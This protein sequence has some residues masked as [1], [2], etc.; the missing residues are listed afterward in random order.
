VSDSDGSTPPPTQDFLEAFK[1]GPSWARGAKGGSKA[2][3]AKFKEFDVPE[4]SGGRTERRGGGRGRGERTDRGGG[5]GFRGERRSGG[6]Q[7]R[8]GGGFRGDRRDSRDGRRDNRRRQGGG[9]WGD[10]NARRDDFVRPAEGVHVE[11]V[12]APEALELIHKEIQQYARVYSLFDIARVI[13]ARRDRYRI[14][15]K[16]NKGRKA[17][18]DCRH[19]NSVWLTREEALAHM[20]RAPWRGEYYDE[21]TIEVDPPKGSFQHVARCGFSGEWLGPTNYHGY[22]KALRELHRERFSDMP[23]ER[24]ASRVRTEHGEEAVAAWLETMKMHTRYRPAGS[25]SD[26]EW[27]TDRGEVERHFAERLFGKAFRETP[28]AESSGDV[29]GTDLSPAL[30]ESLK[31]AGAHARKHPAMLIPAVCRMLEKEHLPVFKRSGKLFTGPARPRVLPTDI[32]L[33]ERPAAIVEWLRERRRAKLADLWKDLLPE[34]QDAP[35]NK[36]LADLFWLLTQGNVLLMS[37]DTLLLPG[38]R[39]APGAGKQKKAAGS[40]DGGEGGEK[41]KTPQKRKRK[42]GRRRR[43]HRRP[44]PSI[45]VRKAVEKMPRRRLKKLRG[46]ERIWRHR[47]KMRQL[48]RMVGAEEE[49][50][51]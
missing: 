11:F 24:Y 51:D 2:D 39:P 19:D 1:L 7:D 34:G 31:L 20:W 37:D 50:D 45:L 15:F 44:R 42:R 9:G 29:A 38:G 22:Q 16:V 26:E 43:R 13:L 17:L 49:D 25:E 48:R 27:M 40:P 8:R 5:G 28:V 21:E 10:R 32:L 46:A 33:A 18:F 12:P 30:L 35:C 14:R 23:F 47:I 6:G 3:S 36:W 4:H 41:T